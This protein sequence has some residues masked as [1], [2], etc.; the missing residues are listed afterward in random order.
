[1]K[2]ELQNYMHYPQHKT[3]HNDK[4]KNINGH[5]MVKQGMAERFWVRITEDG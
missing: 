3:K 1:M 4:I 2:K 5:I